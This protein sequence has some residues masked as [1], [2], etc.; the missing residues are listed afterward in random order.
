MHWMLDIAF[1]EGEAHIHN[2][3]GILALNVLRRIAHKSFQTRH[4]QKYLHGE[5]EDSG[6]L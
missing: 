3:N 1:R 2:C 5:K 6:Y 4:K